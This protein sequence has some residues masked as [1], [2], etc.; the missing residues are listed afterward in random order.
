MVDLAGK[1]VE[2]MH[3]NWESFLVNELEKDY[4]KSQY[5]GYEF[6]FS[7][8]IVLIAFFTWKMPEGSTFPEIEPSE[9]LAARF[10]TLWYTN[11]MSKL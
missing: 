8:L 10:S 1:C 2:G 3:M 11:N 9:L 7:I 5:R 4:H 6:H